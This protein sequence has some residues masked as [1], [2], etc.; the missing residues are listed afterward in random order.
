[1]R[2]KS[3]DR[4]TAAINRSAR[5]MTGHEPA[6]REIE[7]KFRAGED[8]VD[9]LLQSPLLAGVDFAPAR[10]LVSV[11]YDT[12]DW[13]L[14]RNGIALRVRRKGRA[15]PVMGL[16]W[17]GDLSGGVF[18]RHE[19]EAAC[20]SG[21]PDLQLLAPAI[22]E[23]IAETIGEHPLAPVFET[24]V[25]RRTATLRFGHSNIELALDDGAI[26]AGEA[27]MPVAEIEL[28][29]KSGNQQDLLEC[30]AALARGSAL[31]LDFEA[32]SDRGYRLAAGEAPKPQRAA[33][34]ALPA[35]INFDDLIAAVLSHTIDHFVANWAA[36]RE[37]DAPESIHQ[38]RV[39]LRRMRS[40]LGVFR[41][42]IKLPE[43][44]DI[45]AEAKR[46]ASG[47]GPAREC[48]AFRMNALAG[49]LGN[50][51]VPLKGAAQL[52][53][54]VE[55]RR[56]NS[57]VQARQLMADPA[58]TMF[59]LQVQSF[60]HRRAWRTAV[61][62]GD[63]G[64]LTSEARPY[65]AEALGRLL[66]RALKRGRHLPDIPD[67]ERHELRIELKN[68]RYA[69]EFFGSLFS[70]GRT[71]RRYLKLVADLQEDLGAHN[72]AATAEAFI[73]S[74]AL[75]S[76]KDLHFA[77]GYLLGWY[78]H[79]SMAAD[80]NLIRKWKTFKRSEGFWE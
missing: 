73:E 45:R 41:R 7:I 37:T 18:S 20:R 49:P 53:A 43:L 38:L 59:V 6:L 27:R 66:R 31:Q 14:R 40:A 54:A 19:M 64:L 26:A 22:R 51:Q 12:D 1:M 39:A 30:A 67:A 36:L 34:L 8:A 16:K 62:A 63:L 61:S 70:E 48:D 15:T 32:K 58:T 9:T 11:Y 33:A 71:L 52:L 78:R 17:T 74:L 3:Q 13:L 47:L 69:A 60:V 23:R 2:S 10:D 44:E 46:I 72:D 42:T 4:S 65:A 79:A 5:S 76:E 35:A 50:R 24:R 68:L 25:K 55:A 21:V 28:E 75:A 57:Y 77:S 29:L 80:I 56:L